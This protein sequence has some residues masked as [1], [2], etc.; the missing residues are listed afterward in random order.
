VPSGR[1]VLAQDRRE[2]RME[3]DEAELA[4]L[5]GQAEL[6]ALQLDLP[7]LQLCDL[8]Q[9]QPGEREQEEDELLALVADRGVELAQLWLL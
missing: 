6:P 5:A 3:R 8:T 7:P 4:A 2:G 1:L 9:P